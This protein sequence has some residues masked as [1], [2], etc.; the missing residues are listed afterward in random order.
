MMGTPGFLQGH[1]EI[2]WRLSAEL[3]N[4]AHRF[5]PL[6]DVEHI[7]ERQRFKVELVRGVVVG[8]HRFRVAVDHDRL[9]TQLL[10]REGRMHAAVVKLDALPYPVRP[11]AQDHHLLSVG[12]RVSFSVSYVE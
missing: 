11:A 8:A 1:G 2:Q 12:L 6:H 3:D 4:H 5:L 10:Q 7:L 9:V